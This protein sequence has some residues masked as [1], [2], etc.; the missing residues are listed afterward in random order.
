[1]EKKHNQRNPLPPALVDFAWEVVHS[2]NETCLNFGEGSGAPQRVWIEWADGKFY[3]T[4]E[5]WFYKG[6][7]PASWLYPPEQLWSVNTAE[8][9][10]TKLADLV[11]VLERD[12]SI[13]LIEAVE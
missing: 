11:G 13:N 6:E 7:I 3:A 5:S 1:M 12:H 9:S 10:Y 8:H 2:E 4:V